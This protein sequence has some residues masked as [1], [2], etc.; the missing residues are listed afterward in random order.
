MLTGKH[1][2]L[3]ITGSIA[4]YKAIFLL[5]ELKKLNARITVILTANAAKFVAP[6]TFQALS[7]EEVITGTFEPGDVSLRHTALAQQINLLLVAPAT[8][9]IIGKFAGGIADDFLSTLYLAVSAP[10]MIAPAMYVQ[11]YQHPAVQENIRILEGRGVEFLGPE[12]GDLACGA[13]GLG[14]L[15]N[16]DY[17]IERVAQRLT[18]GGALQGKRILICAGPTQEPI[19]KVRFLSN[20]SSGKMGYCLAQEAALRGAQVILISGPTYLNPPQVNEFIRVE[21]AEQMYNAVRQHYENVDAVIMAAAVADYAPA[22]PETGKLK[23]TNQPWLLELKP[24]ADILAELGKNKQKQILIGFAAET[25]N[26]LA[27]AQ[28]KVKAKNLDLIVANDVSKPGVGFG[29]ET[30]Q[31]TIIDAQGNTENL[32][33][34]PKPQVAQRILDR[35]QKFWIFG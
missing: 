13:N 5:R 21:T 17:I 6:L 30:N 20:P 12:A 25:E 26:V 19:D 27:N 9:N 3:G 33:L 22:R 11:M 10:T 35:L 8:A 16:G 34:M 15:I 14:R 7:G 29:V 4:A 32:P 1:V 2:G 31:V 28:A 18:Q 24:T 23:K